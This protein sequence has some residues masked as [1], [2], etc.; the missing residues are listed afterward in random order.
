MKAFF[1]CCLFILLHLSAKAQ[2]VGGTHDGYDLAETTVTILPNHLPKVTSDN[3]KKVLLNNTISAEN[4][5]IIFEDAYLVQ[6]ATLH[7]ASGQLV[8]QTQPNS[9][10][11]NLKLPS[12]LKIGIYYLTI[13]YSTAIIQTH[14]IQVIPNL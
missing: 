5:L 6:T 8:W 11:T 9:I 3:T 14:R 7:T 4:S 10:V 1:L 2:F 12:S 13:F